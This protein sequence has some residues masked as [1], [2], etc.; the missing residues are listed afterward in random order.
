MSE[1]KH[2]LYIE[3]V[4]CQMNMLDSEMVVASLRREGYELT[5]NTKEADTLLFNTCSVRQHAEDKT[6]SAL[7]RLRQQKKRDPSKIIGV[8]GC[9]AQKDQKLIFERAPYVDLIVGPGQLHQIPEL[10]RNAREG[11]QWQTALSMGRTDGKVLDIKRSHET[12]DPLRDPTMRPTPFQAYLRIQIGCDKFCTYCI[13]PMTR[14]PEQGRP[15]TQI[16]EEATLLAQQG[17]KEITLLGQTVNSYKFRTPE[18]DVTDM[19]ALL[20]KLHPIE[21]LERIKFITNYPKD[22]TEPLLETIRDLPKVSPYLHVPAQHGCDN[23]LKRMKRGYTTGDYYAMMDRIDKILGDRAAISSDFIVGFCGETDEEFERT[24]QLVERC[25]FKNSFIFKYSERPGTRSAD[26]LPD[27]V[28][29]D[30][31]KARNN[32]LLAI[33]NRISEEDNQRFLQQTV[34]VLVEGPSKKANTDVPPGTPIQ[35]TGRTHCDRICVFEGN[36]RLVGEMIPVG[37]YDCTAFTL[38]GTVITSEATG[39]RI[40]LTAKN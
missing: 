13:V 1:P 30:V 14:G 29:I 8:M 32:H 40:Q 2:K 22:M 36:P 19:A 16:F 24:C 7:G 9:M 18:G 20:E 5:E 21:G 39:D 33:Q 10:I 26:N 12:Y 17:C 34:E 23:V 25:R 31:K 11:A 37:I 28:P 3:T 27:D 15:P 35:L 4:G 38:M 6:Y